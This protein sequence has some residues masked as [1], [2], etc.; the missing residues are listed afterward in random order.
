MA[1]CVLLLVDGSAGGGLFGRSRPRR[2]RMHRVGLRCVLPSSS[3]R[4]RGSRSCGPAG[5]CCRRFRYLL[6]MNAAAVTFDGGA[7]FFFLFFF[8]FLPGLLGPTTPASG[9]ATLRCP[10]GATAITSCFCF[11]AAVSMLPALAALAVGSRGGPP[12]VWAPGEQAGAI[13]VSLLSPQEAGLAGGVLL[14]MPPSR[15]AVTSCAESTEASA[16]MPPH[17][18]TLGVSFPLPESSPQYSARE[19]REPETGGGRL[20]TRSKTYTIREQESSPIA[21]CRSTPCTTASG[22]RSTRRSTWRGRRSPSTPS[23][24]T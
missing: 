7:S 3:R 11:P 2:C 9:G 15:L 10:S 5:R 21:R 24:L 14:R 12:P 4:R 13:R 18:T 23:C 19:P 17:S 16:P 6:A 1:R 20:G 8:S 22:T